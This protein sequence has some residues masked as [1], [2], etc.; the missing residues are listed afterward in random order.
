MCHKPFVRVLIVL[1]RLCKLVYIIKDVKQVLKGFKGQ[2]QY[3]IE[4]IFLNT[5][6]QLVWLI[7]YQRVK[8][9]IFA[10]L[11]ELYSLLAYLPSITQLQHNRNCNECCKNTSGVLRSGNPL[12][13]AALPALGKPCPSLLFYSDYQMWGAYN[14]RKAIYGHFSFEVTHIRNKNHKETCNLI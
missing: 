12:Q 9:I 8:P 1:Q 10:W 2:D 4:Y 7:I 3:F 6:F 14:L 11:I 13:H 5:L